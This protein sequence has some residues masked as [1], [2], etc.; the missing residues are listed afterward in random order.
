RSG[1]KDVADPSA[2]EHVSAWTIDANNIIGRNDI[3]ASKC[4]QDRVKTARGV[5][6][7]GALSHSRIG[8]ASGVTLERQ[9]PCGDVKTA[10]CVGSERLRADGRIL[11]ALSVI[12]KR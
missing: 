4:A 3:G 8:N 11:G 6:S 2:A 10:G 1:A 7:Q 12:R 9:V 5:V